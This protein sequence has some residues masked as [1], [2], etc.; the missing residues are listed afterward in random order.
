[1]PELPDVEIYKRYLDATSL[2][3]RIR[4][5]E[6]TDKRILE[7]VSA[8][9]L[10]SELK[11]RKLGPTCRHGKYL[12]A[13]LS[14]SRWLVLHFG[15]TGDLSYYKEDGD[16]PE[17]AR[18]I[19]SFANGYRLAYISQRLLGKV[20]L[21]VDPEGYIEGK[22]LGP[23]ALALDLKGFRQALG[24]RAGAKS[25]LMNQRR[26][27]GLGNVYSDEVLYL[28]G[29]HP[30]KVV[31][32]LTK[33]QSRKLH[34]AMR[35]VLE[36]AVRKKADPERMPGGWLF[37]LRGQEGEKCPRCGGTIR[38]TKAAGRTAWYCPSHQRL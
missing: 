34:R 14:T 31:G 38:S 2:H 9:G 23:D 16:A 3:K 26:I 1:M 25:A 35:H 27:A 36:T 32:S 21:A 30:K 33:E 5:A 15:M 20:S 4:R 13:G 19:L 6:V 8:S 29:V 7:G 17:H 10:A 24:R 18:L 11:G 37:H 28:A 22:G 12:F